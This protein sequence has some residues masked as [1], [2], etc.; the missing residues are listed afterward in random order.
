MEAYGYVL[1]ALIWM[2]WIVLGLVT[3]YG[4]WVGAVE[5][6]DAIRQNRLTWSHISA[7]LITVAGYAVS[8]FVHQAPGRH[9]D[10]HVVFWHEVKVEFETG[11]YSLIRSD[12]NVHTLKYAT[13]S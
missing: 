10:G 8:L 3:A 11:P 12:N 13:H 1:Q 7:A 2:A 6:Y 4:T 9:A 5:L